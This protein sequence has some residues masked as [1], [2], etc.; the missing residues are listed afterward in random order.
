MTFCG[1][2]TPNEIHLHKRPF[3]TRIFNSGSRYRSFNKFA[4]L[5]LRWRSRRRVAFLKCRVGHDS[6]LGRFDRIKAFPRWKTSGIVCKF[7]RNYHQKFHSYINKFRGNVWQSLFSCNASIVPTGVKE[8]G[9]QKQGR[10]LFRFGRRMKY[11]YF[12]KWKL[13]S[14]TGLNAC[15]FDRP[16]WATAIFCRDGKKLIKHNETGGNY[17]AYAPGDVRLI[18]ETS[19]EWKWPFRQF[20]F[21][22]QLGRFGY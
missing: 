18:T 16:E 1:I 8:E 9:C 4:R 15:L 13:L 3:V 7:R 12:T 11:R 21:C 14:W 10:A 20:S 5:P 22:I 17:G 19:L 2:K 6:T